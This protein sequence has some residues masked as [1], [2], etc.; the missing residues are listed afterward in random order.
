M[1][2]CSVMSNSL[3][4][5]GLQPTRLLCPCDSPGKKAGVGCHFL[6]QRNLPTSGIEPPFPESPALQEDSLPLEPLGKPSR[7]LTVSLNSIISGADK[8]EGSS[9]GLTQ[10]YSFLKLSDIPL[11]VTTLSI[12]PTFS[13]P[14]WVHTSV[15]HVCISVLPWTQVHRYHLSRFHTYA[16]N[17]KYLSFSFLFTSLCTIGCR[18]ICPNARCNTFYNS[19]DMEAAQMSINR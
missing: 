9:L 17:I 11:Y 2:A 6:L 7:K 14:H 12:C 18:S 19:Q 1:H 5:H 3:R 10:M 13:L 16:F 4:P 8:R 15:L